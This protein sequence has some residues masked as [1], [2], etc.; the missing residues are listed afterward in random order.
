MKAKDT[1]QSRVGLFVML[2]FCFLPWWMF[3]RPNTQLW[4]TIVWVS[5]CAAT[6]GLIKALRSWNWVRTG[7]LRDPGGDWSSGQISATNHLTTHLA[8][9]L[10]QLVWFRFSIDI[11]RQPAPPQSSNSGGFTPFVQTMLGFEIILTALNFFLVF[12]RTKLV[13]N[14]Q[15]IGGD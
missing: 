6:Y 4:L 13:R 11:G 9:F 10:V 12:R 5:L 8:L 3:V 7:P 15:R 1:S 2:A 14:V